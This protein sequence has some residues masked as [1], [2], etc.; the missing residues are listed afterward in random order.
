MRFDGA[1]VKKVILEEGVEIIDQGE[2][3]HLLM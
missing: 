2:H 3:F 1:G